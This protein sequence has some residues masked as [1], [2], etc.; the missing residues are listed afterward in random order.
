MI[1]F[2]QVFMSNVL[3]K[4]QLYQVPIVSLI[5][6]SFMELQKTFL[7]FNIQ[8]TNNLL[9]QVDRELLT[10]YHDAMGLV[11]KSTILN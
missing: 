5:E 6:D 4:E 11:C 7:G 1:P 9:Q 10:A 8:I 2:T 3:Q